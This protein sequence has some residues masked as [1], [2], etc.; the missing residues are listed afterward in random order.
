M[1]FR[2]CYMDPMQIQKQM[3]IQSIRLSRSTVFIRPSICAPQQYTLWTIKIVYISVWKHNRSVHIQNKNIPRPF[4]MHFNK[5]QPQLKVQTRKAILISNNVKQQKKKNIQMYT[6]SIAIE[7]R[8]QIGNVKTIWLSRCQANRKIYSAK[9]VF[10][11]FAMQNELLN[12]H[13]SFFIIESICIFGNDFCRTGIFFKRLI[14]DQHLLN[15]SSK[16]WSECESTRKH[17]R[18]LFISP[19]LIVMNSFLLFFQFWQPTKIAINLRQQQQHQQIT[20]IHIN[21]K[22]LTKVIT[23]SLA[24]LL[25]HKHAPMHVYKEFN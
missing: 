4:Q 1:F 2:V 10:Y 23:S 8:A 20:Q 25:A 12:F 14:L 11:S 15:L 16:H 3:R 21:A 6:N 13:F 5:P 9:V 24:R 19:F 18:R 22:Q 7:H 17:L